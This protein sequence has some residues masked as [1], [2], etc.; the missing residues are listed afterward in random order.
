MFTNS[1]P[2]LNSATGTMESDWAGLRGDTL[3]F[4]ISNSDLTGWNTRTWTAQ[5]RVNGADAAI[6]ATFDVTDSSDSDS[7][8]VYFQLNTEDIE[9]GKYVFDVQWFDE[10]NNITETV[11]MGKVSIKQ[12]VTRDA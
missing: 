11:L 7:V 2:A 10:D 4:T 9:V 1:T 12:D 6:K 5:L 8:S 3:Y